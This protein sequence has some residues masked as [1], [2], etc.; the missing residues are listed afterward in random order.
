MNLFTS[1]TTAVSGRM[2]WRVS[3]DRIDLE[4]VAVDLMG[5]PA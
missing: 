1:K 4:R 5:L 2:D 3:R